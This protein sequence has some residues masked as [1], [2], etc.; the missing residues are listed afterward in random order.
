MT[1]R[2]SELILRCMTSQTCFFFFFPNCLAMKQLIITFQFLL[3]VLQCQ[4]LGWQQQQAFEA[5]HSRPIR[6]QAVI[7]NRPEQVVMTS[8]PE[9]HAFT[10]KSIY[11]H[12]SPNGPTPGLFRKLDI[13]EIR[14]ESL[15][16]FEIRSKPGDTFRPYSP[17]SIYDL[18]KYDPIYGRKQFHT[19]EQMTFEYEWEEG[20]LP[21]VA[22][23]PTVT[24][25]AMMTNNAYSAT[26]NE[27]EWYDIGIP[28]NLVS[29]FL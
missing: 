24:A 2:G 12:A 16:P 19:T 22:H 5:F 7:R 10:L 4:G 15:P 9:T 21:D 26:S 20:A 29:S 6:P 8:S 23:R 25:L 14:A 27:T 13:P 1:G 11:H 28:W 17:E 18:Y 3:L